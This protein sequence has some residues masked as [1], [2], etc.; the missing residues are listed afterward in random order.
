MNNALALLNNHLNEIMIAGKAYP[1]EKVQRIYAKLSSPKQPN[2][3]PEDSTLFYKG[4]RAMGYIE[5]NGEVGFKTAWPELADPSYGNPQGWSYYNP[6]EEGVPQVSPPPVRDLIRMKKA[7][8][9]HVSSPQGAGLYHN[10]PVS[11]NRG[12]AYAEYGFKNVPTESAFYNRLQY[13]DHRRF[14]N[15]PAVAELLAIG[16]AASLAPQVAGVLREDLVARHPQ[17]EQA[18][19]QY[20]L[21]NKPQLRN[22]LLN[23]ANSMLQRIPPNVSSW[24]SEERIMNDELIQ[25][26]QETPGGEDMLSIAL[27]NNRRLRALYE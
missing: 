25:I 9:A 8:Q 4:Q 24:G 10:T 2:I 18:V 12:E 23:R 13:A 27:D 17:I 26:L 11:D 21:Q 20:Q 1:K 3:Y 7:W 14:K 19:N 22:D 16:D 5:P 15:S 6:V